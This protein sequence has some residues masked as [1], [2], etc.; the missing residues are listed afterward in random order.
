[1]DERANSIIGKIPLAYFQNL[2]KDAEKAA[3]SIRSAD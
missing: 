3:E 1:M 2:H